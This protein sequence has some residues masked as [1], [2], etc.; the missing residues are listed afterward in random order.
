[1]SHL[2]PKFVAKAKASMVRS[3]APQ[4]MPR[5]MI[6]YAATSTSS[7]TKPRKNDPEA[8]W[9]WATFPPD[10]RIFSLKK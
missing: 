8:G 7:A 6:I 4:A 2:Q 5:S 3:R 10:Y 9:F 1:M